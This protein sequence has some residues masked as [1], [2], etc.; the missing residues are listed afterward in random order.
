MRTPPT[1][2]TRRSVCSILELLARA[3]R[4]RCPTKKSGRRRAPQRLDVGFLL[5]GPEVQRA[6]PER[7]KTGTEDH[8][9][10][11]QVGAVHDLFVAATLAF[12]NQRIDQFA[13]QPLQLEGVI[14]LLRLGL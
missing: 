6:A 14:G 1:T 4:R 13:P 9:R 11:D 12:A 8:A 2:P 5:V 3:R 7:R 10:I